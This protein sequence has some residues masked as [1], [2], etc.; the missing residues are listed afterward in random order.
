M[1]SDDG[2][3]DITGYKIEVSTNGTSWSDLE[4]NTNTTST[5]YSHTGLT[6]GSTRHYRVSA[7][8]SEGTGPASD[9]DSATT[10]AAS[11]PDLTVDAPTVDDSSLDVGDSF[12]LSITVRNQGNASSD[13]ARLSYQQ[14]LTDSTF[15]SGHRI[16]AVTSMAGLAVSGSSSESADLTAPPSSGT[17]Y[18]RV[19]VFD[20]SDESDTTN[21]CS[22]AVAVTVSAAS[23]PGAPTGLTATADGQTEIDLSWTAPLD[24]GGASITGYKIEVSTNGTSWSNLE[25]NTGSTST[26]YSHT[27]LTAG[28]TRHYRVSAIN[29]EGTGAA[30][31]TDSATTDSAPAQ[32]TTC[33]VNLVVSAGESCTYPG[34]SDEFSVDSS[35]MASFLSFSSGSSIEIRNTTVNGVEY[36]LV[37]SKQSDGTWKIE[38]VG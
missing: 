29:S 14:S 16:V 36:T 26:S 17:Y 37:A 20:V 31:G 5:S 4:A 18:Y 19:C 11:A 33:T 28:S 25:A 23:A 12:T 6:A 3:E 22:S 21:N 9:S 7:I 27:G 30:S 2:G 10:D 38:E 15:G 34:R 1:P 8:N 32:A 13:S 24:D 35:G